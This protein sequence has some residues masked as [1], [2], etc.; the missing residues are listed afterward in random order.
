MKHASDVGEPAGDIQ[1]TTE[2]IENV[3][4]GI[5]DST[6]DLCTGSLIRAAHGK[7]PRNDD[8]EVEE[9]TERGDSNDN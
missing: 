2:D 9:N 1:K 5:R 6:E 4:E 8:E 3:V 7:C